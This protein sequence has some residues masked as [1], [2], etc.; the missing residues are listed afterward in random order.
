MRAPSKRWLALA[1]I[2]FVSTATLAWG[3]TRLFDEE[4]RG[5][6]SEVGIPLVVEPLVTGRTNRFR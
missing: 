2:I 4:V 1:S 3:F 6:R 5:H